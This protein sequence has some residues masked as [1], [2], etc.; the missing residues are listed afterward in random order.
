MARSAT[1]RGVG[2]DLKYLAW[3]RTLRCCVPS[4]GVAPRPWRPIEAH[5]AGDHGFSQKA[6]DSTAIPLC[7]YHHQFGPDAIHGPLGR[8]FW[9]HHG[10]DREALI[11]SLQKAYAEG[12]A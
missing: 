7:E 6:P 11:A 3:I 5:H 9:A 2:R 8:K 12:R 1:R 10:L 4:C